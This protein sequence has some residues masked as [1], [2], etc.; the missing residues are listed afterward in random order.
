M[1]EVVDER[2][3]DDVYTSDLPGS[4]TTTLRGLVLLSM[5]WRQAGNQGM[6]GQYVRAEKLRQTSLS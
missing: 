4:L 6:R 1:S 2:K 3:K 5:E